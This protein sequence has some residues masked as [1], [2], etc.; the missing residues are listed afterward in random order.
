MATGGGKP[1][2]TFRAKVV[3]VNETSVTFQAVNDKPSDYLKVEDDGV[4]QFVPAPPSDPGSGGG[5][6]G[7]S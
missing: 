4:V 3:S 1:G 7:N 2:V 6:P 5:E